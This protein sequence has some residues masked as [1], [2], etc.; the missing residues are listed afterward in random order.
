MA[1]RLGYEAAHAGDA[2]VQDGAGAELPAWDGEPERQLVPDA[3]I[4]PPADVLAGWDLEVE[5]AGLGRAHAVQGEAAIVAAVDHL[6]GR[7]RGLREDAQP[8][9]RVRPLG[10]DP[11]A[12]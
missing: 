8:G 2:L 4:G 9:E 5:P 1:H 11:E 10:D 3:V 12:A 6:V 7:R